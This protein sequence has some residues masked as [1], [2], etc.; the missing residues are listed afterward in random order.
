MGLYV[1]EAYS[2]TRCSLCCL[3]VWAECPI[4]GRSNIAGQ[5][6]NYIPWRIK[7]ENGCTQMDIC[8]TVQE[9]QVITMHYKSTYYRRIIERYTTWPKWIRFTSIVH[10]MPV[11]DILDMHLS[12]RR[13]LLNSVCSYTFQ[14][15]PCVINIDLILIIFDFSWHA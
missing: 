11:F 9:Q 3:S 5:T 4:P 1:G 8:R 6:I 10:Q 2:D 13:V 15:S 12:S 7:M 14:Q